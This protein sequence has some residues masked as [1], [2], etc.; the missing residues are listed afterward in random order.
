MWNR[1]TCQNLHGFDP[2]SEIQ[3]RKRTNKKTDHEWFINIRIADDRI[4]SQM[5]VSGER[6][7]LSE[8]NETERASGQ[9]D[10]KKN[11]LDRIQK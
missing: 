10:D 8:V 6:N 9:T 7:S 2:F 11:A 3:M 1:F 5:I 4:K